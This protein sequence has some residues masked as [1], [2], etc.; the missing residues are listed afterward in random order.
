MWSLICKQSTLVIKTKILSK[1]SNI[2]VLYEIS[3]NLVAPTERSQFFFVRKMEA[4]L[5]VLILSII[6]D[7]YQ[8]KM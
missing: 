5:T 3:T 4:L 2:A 7:S 6:F 1:L 8:S